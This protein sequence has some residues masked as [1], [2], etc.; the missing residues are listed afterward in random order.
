[1]TMF[2]G[3][4]YSWAPAA[5]GTVAGNS[6]L[7]AALRVLLIPLFGALYSSSLVYGVFAAVSGE[8]AVVASGLTVGFLAGLVYLG[9]LMYAGAR[10]LR[11]HRRLLAG[12]KL[13]TAGLGFWMVGGGAVTYAA[14]QAGSS[15]VLGLGAGSMVLSASALGAL[16]TCRLIG[17]A[18]LGGLRPAWLVLA[19]KRGK[20]GFPF[21]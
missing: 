9:P 19:W 14:L 5:A 6:A 4:Y 11:V 18:S 20:Q 2:N 21:P 16:L 10:L 17:A 7:A 12:G 3:W 1:M 13:K 8:A 15:I